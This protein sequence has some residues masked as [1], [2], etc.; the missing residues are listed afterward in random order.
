MVPKIVLCWYLTLPAP[1]QSGQVEN[2]VPSFAPVPAHF[3]QVSTLVTEIVFVVPR[4]ASLSEIFKLKFISSPRYVLLALD[5]V[6]PNAENMSP[7]TGNTW[8][9]PRSPIK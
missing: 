1:L 6:P 2:F 8:S 7:K 4:H 9:P 5:L 3:G